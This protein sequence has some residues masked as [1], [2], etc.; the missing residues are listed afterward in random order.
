[1]SLITKKKKNQIFIYYVLSIT[2]VYLFFNMKV[3]E[4]LNQMKQKVKI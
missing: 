3:L 1:M 4:T 2:F